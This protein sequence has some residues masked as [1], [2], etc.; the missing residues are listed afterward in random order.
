MCLVSHFTKKKLGF[1]PSF[2]RMELNTMQK[3]RYT[4]SVLDF[5]L[6]RTKKKPKNSY[7]P[8]EKIWY[9]GWN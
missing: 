6:K 4:F 3:I 2:Y 5:G 1:D 8:Y 7:P 9:F